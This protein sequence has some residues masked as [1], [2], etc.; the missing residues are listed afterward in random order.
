MM[1][2]SLPQT[3]FGGMESVGALLLELGRMFFSEPEWWMPE[4]F[5]DLFEGA[6]PA[7][8][9]MMSSLI[10]LPGGF[11]IFLASGNAWACWGAE[12]CGLSSGWRVRFS[13]SC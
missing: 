8:A 9:L 10:L 11:L 13:S 6:L 1:L 2:A 4:S 12:F 5:V 3:F 7:F